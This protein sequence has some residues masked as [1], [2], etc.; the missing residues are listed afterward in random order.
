MAVKISPVT[1]TAIGSLLQDNLLAGK[2]QPLL[3]GTT[4][5]E[6]F[7]IQQ[8]AVLGQ[9]ENPAFGYYAIGNKGHTSSII[10]GTDTIIDLYK[11]APEDCACW[12]HIPFVL[13]AE[14]NDLSA[15]LR[16]N[17]GLRRAE[18]HGG[19]NYFAYY[20]KRVDLSGSTAKVTRTKIVN[21]VKDTKDYAFTSANLN[22]VRPIVL[23]DEATTTAN[24]F[25]ATTMPVTIKFDLFDVEELYNVFEVLKGTA[26]QAIISELAFC[27]GVDRN[28]PSIGAGGAAIT[29]KEV[30]GCQVIT[31]VT[32]Y[33][34]LSIDN[35]GFTIN[36][37]LG[38][39][40]PMLTGT[41][42]GSTAN[43]DL[44]SMARTSL[45]TNIS[46]S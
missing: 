26:K 11:H 9:G 30:I 27:S 41:A 8:N 34:Q 5:N 32:T 7:Q 12:N 23:P 39:T 24:D 10:D 28:I 17:Y 46:V 45:L 44:L 29:V 35:E 40:E 15:D 37:E 14:A 19:K 36:M 42:L 13:R 18:Q 4:L 38:A 3:T 22:P 16:L 20:L 2:Q 21:G 31:F 33:K 1:R 43:N 25:L 6:L